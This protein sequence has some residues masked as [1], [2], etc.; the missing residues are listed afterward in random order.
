M[1]VSHTKKYFTNK[2]NSNQHYGTKSKSS[3]GGRK[4]ELG[5]IEPPTFCMRNRRSTTEL[6]P[7]RFAPLGFD[8]RTF[9][10]WAQH[11]SSAPRSSYYMWKEIGYISFDVLNINLPWPTLTASFVFFSIFRQL[12]STS[13][14][15][16]F[17][18]CNVLLLIDLAFPFSYSWHTTWGNSLTSFDTTHLFRQ[19]PKTRSNACR[20]MVDTQ[21]ITPSH[22]RS[23]WGKKNIC[24]LQPH[25]FHFAWQLAWW[26]K[27]IVIFPSSWL[28]H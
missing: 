24:S 27:R 2:N 19:C 7:Q 26:Q 14:I 21:R 23:Q 13:Y 4:V 9:G 20:T 22:G 18:I 16:S 6:Q 11:A 8:P 10:L 3:R 15:N 12:G 25:A 1:I 17:V 28:F 5:G